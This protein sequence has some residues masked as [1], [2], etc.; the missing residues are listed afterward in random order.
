MGVSNERTTAV[1]NSSQSNIFV[2]RVNDFGTKQSTKG[3]EAELD[4]RWGRSDAASNYSKINDRCHF[5]KFVNQYGT[6]K[7]IGKPSNLKILD[8]PCGPG[9]YARRLLEGGAANVTSVDIDENFVDLCGKAVKDAG[10]I[11]RWHGVVADASKSATYPGAPFDVVRA[12][13][14]LEVFPD[15]E[16]MH[17]AAKNLFDNLKEGGRY[18]GI[19]APGAHSPAARKIVIDTVGM[20]TSDASTMVSGDPSCIKYH[21]V[22]EANSYCWY[23]RTRK[24]IGEALETA[25][26]VD[27]VFE[28]MTVDPSYTGYQDLQKFVDH[29]GNRF[30]L[31]RKPNK[32]RQ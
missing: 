15:R 29:V 7:H 11:T 19:W 30:V 20:E 2:N 1:V 5:H 8:L 16:S 10:C 27:V 13:F 28:K 12:N 6:L 23:F 22:G 3:A 25:G 9:L 26:F 32:M 31:A 4:C 21:D 17:T 18:I 14:L 24:D